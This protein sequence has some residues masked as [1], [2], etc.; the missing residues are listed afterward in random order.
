MVGG[1]GVPDEDLR[2]QLAEVE[3]VAADADVDVFSGV[4]ANIDTDGS[5]SV[6]D[7]LLAELDV[8]VASPHAGLD[9]DGTERLVAAAEHPAVNIIGHPTGR[10]L[11]RRAGLDVDV[12]R[13]A[14]VAADHDTALEVNASPARLD[15]D[16]AL[17]QRAVDAGAPIA[18]DTDAHSPGSFEQITYGVHTARRGWAEAADVVNTW[19]VDYLREFLD[20]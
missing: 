3:A 8:V 11:N 18:I 10:Y 14:E 16:G 2:E 1:V 9:G 6:A 12:D 7:D 17:V 15:L 4:E 19:S 13:V 20:A 5:L